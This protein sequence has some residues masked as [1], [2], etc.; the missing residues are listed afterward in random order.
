MMIKRIQG[1]LEE[2][3][4]V[5]RNAFITVADEFHLTKENAPTNPAFIGTDSLERMRDKGAVLFGAY[6]GESCIGFVAA[7]QA[8]EGA[9]YMERL[10]VLPEYRHRGI[11]RKLMDSV[12]EYVRENGGKRVSIGIINKNTKLKNWYLNYG[13]VETGLKHFDHL[14]FEV[15]FM[16]KPV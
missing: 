10:A 13:F 4:G 11:G 16:E 7:E 9:F 14:P 12:F 1:D 15:C 6:E 2:C 3:T 5:I 8:S